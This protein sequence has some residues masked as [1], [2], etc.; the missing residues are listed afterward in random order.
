MAKTAILSV[1]ITSAADGSG[2]R[3]AVR[4]IKGLEAAAKA[5]EKNTNQFAKRLSNL[6]KSA[7]QLAA[8]L[9]TTATKAS[10]LTTAIGG[11]AAPL[12]AIGAA[13]ASAAVPLTALTASLAPA[14]LGA[15]ALTVGVLKSALDGFGEAL[16]ASDPQSFAAALDDMPP[17]AASAARAL[18]A[19]QHSFGDLGK[20]VQQGFW[21]RVENIDRLSHLIEPIRFSMNRLASEMGTATNRLVT[22]VSEGA[23]LS[24]MRGLIQ[25][26]GTAAASLAHAF[27]DL[28]A[29]II[30]AGAAAAPILDTLA[31][32]LAGLAAQW[33]ARMEFDFI[34][35]SLADYFDAAIDKSAALFSTLGQIGGIVSGVFSAMAA[36]GMPFL[37][38]LGQIIAA[39]DEWVNSAA[40]MN[41]LQGIFSA[42]S[43]AV[44]SV[45]PIVGQ[46]AAIVGGTLAPAFAE[47]V[48]I[49]APAVGQIV[50]ALSGIIGSILPI[51]PVVGQIAAVIGGAL[52]SAISAVTP[53]VAQLADSIGGALVQA[54]AALSPSMPAIQAAFVQIG[55][56]VQSL[57]PALSALL[58]AFVS[59]LGPIG[60]LVGA[61]L[62]GLAS[63]LSAVMP[64]VSAVAFGLSDLLGAVAPLI[65]LVA[66]L[67]GPVL[68]ALAAIL[69]FVANAISPVVRSV[70]SL[71]LQVV[72]S[73]KAVS[74]L[75]TAF[76]AIQ[77]ALSAASNAFNAVRS[78]IAAV[79]GAVATLVS[80]LASIRWPS[81]PAW[82]GRVFGEDFTYPKPPPP[83]VP[84][85]PQRVYASADYPAALMSQ[86]RGSG[87]VVNITING[88]LDARET[89]EQ[90]RKVLRAD[91]RTRGLVSAGGY[92]LWQ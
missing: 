45:L 90:I 69:G 2:F 39:T 73:S 12:A 4:H 30:A 63:I 1:R 74:G 27:S 3:K 80:R 11:A 31:A 21:A 50:T 71:G 26:S 91:A 7:G 5:S 64:V 20:E 65:D 23:G 67:A 10:A 25:H 58:S 86:Y 28:T 78:A 76:G 46:L 42:L 83:G 19:L 8:G 24:A 79:A 49:V 48:T 92:G 13:A 59:L 6:G 54:M 88:A 60:S 75:R 35:G 41:T 62:P 9:A 47:L 82:F 84:G 15:A 52:A 70:V 34:D 17:A 33:S 43:A 56:A 61:V 32:K 36:A 16:N 14:A 77:G 53:I 51:V 57:M 55:G 89:A 37:G 85:I 87:A 38:T 22:F 29:G 44:G 66:Q 68:G 40:G 72:T 81:P 18:R